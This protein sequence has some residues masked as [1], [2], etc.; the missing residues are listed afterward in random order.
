MAT[1]AD[2]SMICHAIQPTRH[3]DIAEKHNCMVAAQHLAD[4]NHPDRSA[5]LERLHTHTVG[6]A[7]H[8]AEIKYVGK[9]MVIMGTISLIIIAMLIITIYRTA[10]ICIEC[11]TDVALLTNYPLV[12][13]VLFV[14]AVAGIYFTHLTYSTYTRPIT[15]FML[16]RAHQKS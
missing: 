12:A 9:K 3:A 13:T 8:V 16:A 6:F 11:G 5:H 7:R 1:P 4:T 15:N 10:V 2:I 14:M